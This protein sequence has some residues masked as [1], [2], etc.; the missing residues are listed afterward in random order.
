MSGEDIF[1]GPISF[2]EGIKIVNEDYVQ[3]VVKYLKTKTL[4]HT[5]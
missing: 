5:N 1:E 3:G 4:A 2:E